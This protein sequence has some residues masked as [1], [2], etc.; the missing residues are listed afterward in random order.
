MIP[1]GR[2][3]ER[4]MRMMMKR[5]G[6]STQAME[7]VVEVVIRRARDEIVL[8]HPEVTE[9]VV[10][11]MKTYQVVGEP[12]TRALGAEGAPSLAAAPP[13]SSPAPAG[14]PEEDVEL[15]MAQAQVDRATALK[16]LSDAHGEPAEA[17]LKL[18][19]RRTG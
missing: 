13:A 19:S 15:V 10:Q 17:I 8:D 5:M 14:P 16:A 12:R 2:M 4:T 3:N 9:V 1:G 7:D 18:M 11:G 6:M